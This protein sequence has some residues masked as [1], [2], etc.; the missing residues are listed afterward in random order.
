MHEVSKPS[1]RVVGATALVAL[2]LW[3]GGCDLG[4]VIGGSGGTTHDVAEV[5]VSDG[6]V[7][8]PLGVSVVPSVKEA[9]SKYFVSIDLLYRTAAGEQVLPMRLEREVG[10]EARWVARVPIP[11]TGPEDFTYRFKITNRHGRV[12]FRPNPMGPGPTAD[13]RWSAATQ[14]ATRP[15]APSPVR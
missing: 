11:A 9:P 14:A 2:C 10:R 15:D 13:Y 5:L 6:H 12:N 1:G 3:I 4:P 7:V 8:V